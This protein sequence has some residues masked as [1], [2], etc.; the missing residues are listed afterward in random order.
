MS[1]LLSVEKPKTQPAIVTIAGDAGVGK[2]SLAALWPKP[3]F[4]RAEDGMQS[5]PDARRPDAFPVLTSVDDLWNQLKALI[6]EEHGYKTLVVDSVTALESMFILNVVETDP[7]KPKSINQALGGYG[8]GMRAVASMHQRVRKAAGMLRAKGMAVVFIAHTDVET[9]DPPDGSPY[10]RM[11]LRLSTRSQQAYIDD[12]DM[13]G[14]LALE[15][16]RR[17]TEGRTDKA[18]TSG[19]R[20]LMCMASAAHV[21]KNRYG[22]T[23]PIA[24]STGINPLSG[25]IPGA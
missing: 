18:I 8:S 15:T 19:E 16:Y 6:S 13:V 21:S 12:V 20:V 17:R 9:V 24:V 22:I 7:N 4:I 5:I 23:E 14:L 10:T 11:S 1:L 2:T 3:I 25:I